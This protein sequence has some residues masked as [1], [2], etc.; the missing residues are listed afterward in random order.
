[1]TGLCKVVGPGALRRST[2]PDDAFNAER[3][4]T[5]TEVSSTNVSEGKEQAVA[6]TD[7]N[8]ALAYDQ[9]RT[10]FFMLSMFD[11]DMLVKQRQQAD[12]FMHITD[13][14]AYGKLINS[15]NA[16]DNHAAAQAAAKFVAALKE[17]AND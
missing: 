2:G 17:L 13:P 11:W 3:K 10:A 15:K 7:N 12:S 8:F 14:T 9:I 1:M 6:I 16:A 5:M 4:R